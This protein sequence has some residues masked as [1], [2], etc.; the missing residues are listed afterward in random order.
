MRRVDDPRRAFLMGAPLP[1]GAA[2]SGAFERLVS[3]FASCYPP[4]STAYPF[5]VRSH[6]AALLLLEVD[7]TSDGALAGPVRSAV[8][9]GGV[10]QMCCAVAPMPM[11]PGSTPRGW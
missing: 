6:D 11:N 9:A 2:S 5:V 3:G 8:L 1:A 10:R 4:R 7:L